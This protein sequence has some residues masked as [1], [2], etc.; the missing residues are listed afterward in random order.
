MPCPRC[1]HENPSGQKFCGACGTL[2]TDASSTERS[3]ADPKSEVES[4]RRALTESLEQQTATAEILRVISSSPTDVQPVFD[5]IV[6]SAA[7]LC[8]GMFCSAFRFDGERL[9]RVASYNFSSEAAETL[10]AM[11]PLSLTR[12]NVGAKAILERGVVH[13]PDI[14]KD[15]ET[16]GT[17]ERA[18]LIGF[19]AILAAPMLREGRAIGT[20]HVG[21][22][23]PGPFTPRQIA[24]LQT[25]AAQAVIAI[26]NVRLF[27]ELEARNRELTESLQQQTATADVLKVISRSAFDLQTVLDTLC[28]SVVRLCDADHAL[29]FQRDGEIVRYAASFGLATEVHAR[30]SDYFRSRPVPVDRG[31]ITG[32]AA[33]EARVVQVA[34]V[35]AD[36]EYAWSGAQEIGDWRAAL[37]APLLR[38]GRYVGVIFVAK[39]VPQPFS[40]KQIELVETFADQ[41]V[42]A[43]ENVRLFQELQTRNAELT[44][45]LEQQTA[46]AEILRVI[47]SSLT[48]LQPVMDVV[49]ESA[50]RFCGA[51]NAAIFRLD[52]ETLRFVAGYG[53]TPTHMPI[54]LSIKIS[55]GLVA[56]RVVSE[57]RTIQ[58]E[59]LLALPE[60]ETL[61]RQHDD[62]TPSRTGACLTAF[63][64]GRGNWPH[65]DATDRGTPLHGEA[66]CAGEDVCGPSRHRDRERPIVHGAAGQEP[67]AH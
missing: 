3:Y 28:E 62:R 15:P 58:V 20:I 9:H 52:G 39:T 5:T 2:L 42:I 46:T 54:G 60:A 24:L 10:R 55:S 18:R 6:K 25:F 37:G 22:R 32:R 30:I 34:D 26:E 47:S 64:Q 27:T 11:G 51:T 63:A 43:I 38:E 8:D 13:V 59:D 35:L 23:D 44:E 67:S 36:T 31:S 50:A 66:D 12:G 45:S 7:R 41:A 53:D 16:V 49:A 40:G 61:A 17:R 48:D 29:L 14:E 4:L 65:L 19:R 33:L 56:G 57:R 1:Q 21:R